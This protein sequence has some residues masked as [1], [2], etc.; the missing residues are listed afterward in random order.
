MIRAASK[1]DSNY[2]GFSLVGH[3]AQGRQAQVTCEANT[4]SSLN[5]RIKAKWGNFRVT[6]KNIHNGPRHQEFCNWFEILF[7]LGSSTDV[8][9]KWKKVEL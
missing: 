5:R 2:I 3:C 9:K 1:K 8:G 4:T 7:D 6:I